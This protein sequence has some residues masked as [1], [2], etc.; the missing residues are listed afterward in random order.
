[1]ILIRIVL[2]IYCF[3]QQVDTFLLSQ[4][5]FHTIRTV[6]SCLSLPARWVHASTPAF[7]RR[8]TDPQVRWTRSFCAGFI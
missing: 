8:A 2:Q 1:M 6:S 4:K 5:L 3:M 7:K